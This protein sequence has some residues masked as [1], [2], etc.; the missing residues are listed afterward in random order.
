MGPVRRC[1]VDITDSE[2]T[3]LKKMVTAAQEESIWR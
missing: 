3:K 2:I 1:S